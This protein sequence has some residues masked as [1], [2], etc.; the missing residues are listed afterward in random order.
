MA[1]AKGLFTYQCYYNKLLLTATYEGVVEYFVI[2]SRWGKLIIFLMIF[3]CIFQF[4]ACHGPKWGV[5]TGSLGYW[6]LLILKKLRT[7]IKSWNSSVT[8]D[9]TINYFELPLCEFLLLVSVPC[10]SFWG[11]GDAH[12]F[13]KG[14]LGWVKMCSFP[15]WGVPRG[16]PPGLCGSPALGVVTMVCLVC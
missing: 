2:S 9:Y 11:G 16:K 7:W 5:N 15:V 4:F 6:I 12:T 3:H 13:Q 14:R 8:L 1:N 10:Q